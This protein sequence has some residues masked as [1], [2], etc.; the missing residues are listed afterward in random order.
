MADKKQIEIITELVEGDSVFE[1]HGYAEIKV[2]RGGDA[3]KIKLPIK[4]HGVAEF[5]EKLSAKA[6]KPPTTFEMI[7]KGSEEGQALG[8]KH[9]QKAVVFDLT[10]EKYIDAKEK[11]DQDFTWRVAVF[12]L[13]LSWKKKDGTAVKTYEE[14]KSI[15]QAAGLTM[16]QMGDIMIAVNALTMFAE[17]QQDFLS[18]D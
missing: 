18:G 2:T 15:L 12:A 11:H 16:H 3:K 7:R 13:D 1:S 10:D 17:D 5:Q 8:L 4:S 6:P 9:H 14:K